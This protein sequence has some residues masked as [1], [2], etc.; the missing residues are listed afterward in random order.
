ML[1][2]RMIMLVLLAGAVGISCATVDATVVINE[3]AD[4]GTSGEYAACQS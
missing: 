1:F 4:K 2:S 3:V